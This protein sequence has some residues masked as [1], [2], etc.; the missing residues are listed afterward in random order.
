[1]RRILC[2]LRNFLDFRPTLVYDEYV[3][4]RRGVWDDKKG[5]ASFKE[6]LSFV[7]RR[8]NKRRP[9]LILLALSGSIGVASAN[10][11]IK[12]PHRIGVDPGGSEMTKERLKEFSLVLHVAALLGFLFF[13]VA[14]FIVHIAARNPYDS[15]VL[16]LVC[17][18]PVF[19]AEV[20]NIL[21]SAAAFL[22]VAV[23]GG[24]KG[25]INPSEEN[26]S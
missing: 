13:I 9:L 20:V 3:E 21:A 17:V 22:G 11:R 4:N 19:V 2:S 14:G 1:M 16:L 6:R 5:A 7:Q 24:A 15:G 23:K 18:T 10:P 26:E 25:P 8:E 12:F